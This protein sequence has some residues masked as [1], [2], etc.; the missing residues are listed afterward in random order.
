MF[1]AYKIGVRIS[2]I[3]NASIGLAALGRDV[4]RTEA[5]FTLLEKRIQS[6]KNMTLK[7]GL[8]VG[9][10]A[11]GLSLLEAPI[12]AAREY[13]LA[14]TKFKTMNLGDAVNKQA[15]QFARSA[16]LMGISAKELMET[17]SESVGLFGHFDTA[18]KLA[19]QIALLNKA[20]SAIFQGKIDHI[21]EGSTR[22]LM[23]F[24]DRRGGTHDEASF[25]RNLDLAQRM[26]TGSGGFLKFRDLDQFSQQ[27]GTA[28]RA[29]SDEGILNMALLLQE[30]GGARAGTSLMSIYQNLVA[31]RTPK[32]TMAMLQEFGLGELTMQEHGTVGGKSM[33]N[34]VMKN[35]KDG[36]LLQS[37]PAEWMRSTLLPA[38]ASKGITDEKGILKAVNDLL[39]N[40]NASGQASIMSTQLLQVMRDANLTKNAMGAQQTIDQYKKDPNSKFADMQAKYNGLLVELGLIAL[41]PVIRALETLIP[42]VRSAATWAREHS[43]ATKLLMGAFAGLAGAMAIGGTVLL[44]TAAFRGLGLA[45]T[46]QAIGGVGGIVKLAAVIGGT[47]STALVGALAALASPIG[48]AVLALGTLAAAAY[49]FRP[50]TQGEIDSYKTE[51]G[52]RLTPEAQRRIAAGE[53]NSG[54]S[55]YVR[56]GAQSGPVALKGDVHIDGR[57]AGQVIWQQM[58]A[59]LGRPQAG[60]STFD[61]GMGMR[62]PSLR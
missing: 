16:N 8:M 35:I 21:D 20:N 19:P 18:Q 2:V 4:L 59:D 50:M 26:V 40:R 39:S 42:M 23:K 37:N 30:Q 6:I 28:F 33:K 24:I 61:S 29:L 52:A 43:T 34:L 31:G 56:P 3:N 62:P 51:G 1:E 54:G 44:L 15:D 10:G 57:K 13:E 46:F 58:N 5:Q 48:I 25:M 9:V 55:R 47:G 49:A 53:L 38:L 17:M 14:F 45:L 36:D 41:P 22:S 60:P 27:G 11:A 12:K 7:G 32:K